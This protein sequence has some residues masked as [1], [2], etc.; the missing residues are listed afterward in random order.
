MQDVREI[1]LSIFRETAVALRRSDQDAFW[2]NLAFGAV[3]G[4]VASD[5]VCPSAISVAELAAFLR[6]RASASTSLA[7]AVRQYLQERGCAATRVPESGQ[8]HHR[9][10]APKDPI[11]RPPR[12]RTRSPRF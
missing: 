3:A 6:Y 2:S 11:D 12:R 9:G 1:P 4:I 10:Q 7:D 8:H 5:I